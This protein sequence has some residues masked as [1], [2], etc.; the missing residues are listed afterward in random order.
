MTKRSRKKAAVIPL[1]KDIQK[2][3]LDELRLF[4]IQIRAR[5]QNT[6]VAGYEG[7]KG[8]RPVRFGTP[9]QADLTC[10]I[11]PTGQRL[12]IEVKR[13]GQKLT[14]LQKQFRDETLEDGAIYFVVTS[15]EDLRVLLGGANIYPR[16]N[17]GGGPTR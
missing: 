13:P 7:K 1:E 5:R 11:R 9:G 6:G 15:I 2:A 14:K 12:E 17:A 10:T 8:F 3:I 4:Y 16:T